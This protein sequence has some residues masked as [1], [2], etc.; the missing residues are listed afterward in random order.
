MCRDEL[1]AP[2]RD[3]VSLPGVGEIA[4]LREAGD[5]ITA[6]PER[7]HKQPHW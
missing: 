6:L 5:F 3:P 1:V 7:E 2:L 4:T